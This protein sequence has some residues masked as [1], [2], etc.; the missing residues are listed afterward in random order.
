MQIFDVVV[1]WMLKKCL[2]TVTDNSV[3][4]EIN[5]KSVGFRLLVV[6]DPD[7][8]PLVLPRCSVFEVHPRCTDAVAELSSL[9]EH[10]AL[11]VVGRGFKDHDVGNRA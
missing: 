3:L 4:R 10:G 8:F 7:T 6:N 2:G 5:C 9:Q 11:A 1:V